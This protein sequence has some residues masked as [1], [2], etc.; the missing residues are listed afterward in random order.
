MICVRVHIVQCMPQAICPR[1][2][3]TS[4]PSR[5]CCFFYP[6][7]RYRF[8]LGCEG[9]RVV[10]GYYFRRYVWPGDDDETLFPSPGLYNNKYIGYPVYTPDRQSS[11]VRVCYAASIIY[12]LLL[13][14][15][16]YRVT[17]GLSSTIV[18]SMEIWS[19]TGE[20]ARLLSLPPRIMHLYTRSRVHRRNGIT[21]TP[22]PLV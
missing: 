13:P 2:P 14:S 3:K 1:A 6:S 12:L 17:R 9:L 19:F 20:Y 21:L 11:A 22:M 16:Q 7:Q 15:L 10:S 4:A 18:K 8:H 5:E